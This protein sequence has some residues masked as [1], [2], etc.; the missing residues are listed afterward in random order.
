M[1]NINMDI[2]MSEIKSRTLG[3]NE[4]SVTYKIPKDRKKIIIEIA[5]VPITMSEEEINKHIGQIKIDVPNDYYP[6]L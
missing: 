6:V 3:T 5:D 1:K 4:M 2:C